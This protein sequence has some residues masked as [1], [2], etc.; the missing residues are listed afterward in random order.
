MSREH[1][2]PRVARGVR[3]YPTP[4][5]GA[6]ERQLGLGARP[7]GCTASMSSRRSKRARTWS[8]PSRSSRRS[9]TLARSTAAERTGRKLLVGQSTR[10]FDLLADVGL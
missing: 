4:S 6:G 1:Y 9:T 2:F 10:F 3:S 8:A 7:T 5:S